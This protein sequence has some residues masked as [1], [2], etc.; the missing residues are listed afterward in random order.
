MLVATEPQFDK[1]SV[2]INVGQRP[3]QHAQLIQL[4]IRKA[5]SQLSTKRAADVLEH[6]HDPIRIVKGE[7]PQQH[8]SNTLK[9]AVVAPMPSAS[10]RPATTAK[11]RFLVRSR[12]A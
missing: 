8:P 2:G 3:R 12:S 6:A 9:I 11:P 5:L 10:V 7:R 1:G 4:V